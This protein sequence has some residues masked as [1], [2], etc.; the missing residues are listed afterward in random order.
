MTVLMSSGDIEKESEKIAKVNTIRLTPEEMIRYLEQYMTPVDQSNPNTNNPLPLP[1]HVH[2]FAQKVKEIEERYRTRIR[3]GNKNKNMR[4]NEPLL[5]NSWFVNSAKNESDNEKLYSAI[6]GILNKLSDKNFELLFE[7]LTLL[8]IE[9]KEQLDEYVNL[10]FIKA[11]REPNYS[12]MYS[13]LCKK[14]SII[15]IDDN[16][17]FREL[18]LNRCQDLF[19]STI[20]QV[21][22]PEDTMAKMKIFGNIKFIGELYNEELLT[23]NIIYGCFMELFKNVVKQNS[24][25]V[26]CIVKL[27]SAVGSNFLQ[28][29]K[30][31]IMKCY[32][33]LQTVKKIP[34]I[35]KRDKFMIMDLEDVMKKWM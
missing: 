26:E 5:K 23:N 2:V 33:R 9:T 21:V 30:K 19:I 31:L 1:N 16:T 17:T 7:E 13:R 22:D 8:N 34:K 4:K 11:I 14:L 35:C 20:A 10:V 3:R 29:D 12:D 15:T 25:A 32:E 28:R 27:M 24:I 18:L 6:N